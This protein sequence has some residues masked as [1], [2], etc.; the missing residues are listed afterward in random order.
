MDMLGG[1]K[2]IPVDSCIGIA[3]RLPITGEVG[4]EAKVAPCPLQGGSGIEV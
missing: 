4:T 3:G 1:V 2:E